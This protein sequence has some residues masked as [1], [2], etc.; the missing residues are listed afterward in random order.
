MHR[1][2]LLVLRLVY[3]NFCL[4]LMSQ[5]QPTRHTSGNAN[6]RFPNLK[7]REIQKRR[8]QKNNQTLDLS[9][10]VI[11]SPPQNPTPTLPF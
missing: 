10:E 6:E 4:D 9:A 1:R 8:P 11:T 2:P 3:H 7:R 5:E